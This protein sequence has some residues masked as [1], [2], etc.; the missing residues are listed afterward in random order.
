M[1]KRIGKYCMLMTLAVPAFASTVVFYG[2]DFDPNNPNAN[3]LANETDAIVGG[4][5]TGSS[6]YQAFVVGAGGWTV[7][8]LF[9]NNLTDL[10]V[11]SAYW[12][13]RSGVSEGNGGTLI[14]SGTDTTPILSL[15]GRTGFGF[16]ELH[17]EVDGLNL[18]LAP[19]TYW[20]TVTPQSGD[21]SRSYNSNTF[22]LNS[23]GTVP[24][25]VQFW[26]SGF[27]GNNFTNANNGGVFPAFSD[28]VITG[29]VTPTPEPGSITLA[30][31]GGAAL[32]FARRRRS[33]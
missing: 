26:N 14:S 16:N 27:F 12:E 15:T 28:G 23:I 10:T 30:L 31:M 24:Q 25:D 11:T 19:G 33:A 9:S 29:G 5:P 4:T 18:F 21:A 17:V 6:T 13:I 32:L 20:M 7:T 8:G 1:F 3:G 22:G 2:G